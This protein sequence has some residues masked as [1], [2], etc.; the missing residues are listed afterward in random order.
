MKIRE[1]RAQR[2][3]RLVRTCSDRGDFGLISQS[4]IIEVQLHELAT[5]GW[6]G[7][8][9]RREL[10]KSAPTRR[11]T[12]PPMTAPM[13]AIQK[14]PLPNPPPTRPIEINRKAK[15]PASKAAAKTEQTAPA[16]MPTRTS[17]RRKSTSHPFG[18]R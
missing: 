18:E 16:I 10:L 11:P 8:A 2:S 9:S 4:Q 7:D 14:S 13:S 6:R 12:N 3:S 15:I 5:H 17:L 1:Q